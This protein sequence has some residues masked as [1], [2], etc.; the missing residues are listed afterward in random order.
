MKTHELKK[1]L[2]DMVDFACYQELIE[3][4]EGNSDSAT[5]TYKN[6]RKFIFT[7]KIVDKNDNLETQ[8]L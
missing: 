5:I 8:E 1:K 6:G 2:T 4:I 3:K 7:F